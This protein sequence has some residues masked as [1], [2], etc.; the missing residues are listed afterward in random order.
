M[1]K[2]DLLLKTETGLLIEPGVKRSIVMLLSKYINEHGYFIPDIQNTEV[3]QDRNHEER[4]IV[5]IMSEDKDISFLVDVGQLSVIAI[6]E[7]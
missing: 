2:T 4:Y 3:L 5:S 1:F 7:T 6:S